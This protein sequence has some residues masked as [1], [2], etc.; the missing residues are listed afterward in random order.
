[1]RYP[2]KKLSINFYSRLDEEQLSSFTQ[3]LTPWQTW[4][5]QSVWVKDSRML[6]CLHR[7]CLVT[8]S[9]ILTM[10]GGSA[11][12]R[13]YFKLCFAFLV[14]GMQHLSEKTISGFPVS[15]GSAEALVKWGGKIRYV[16][17]AYCLSNIFAKNCFIRMV[18][19]KII[20]SQR[21]HVFWHSVKL[22]KLKKILVQRPRYDYESWHN[23]T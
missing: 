3:R 12:T 18:Y 15:P 22:I 4:I 2:I 16:L 19:V 9:I 10:K 7:S 23:W 6:C 13:W 14:K 11:L 1:V 21:W 5:V 20:A 8:Q 17:I